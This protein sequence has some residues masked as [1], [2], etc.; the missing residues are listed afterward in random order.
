MQTI[1]PLKLW[2]ELAHSVLKY[3]NVQLRQQ[4]YRFNNNNYI[5]TILQ[6]KNSIVNLKILV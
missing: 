4:T 3:I 2:F 6:T 1:G 5:A